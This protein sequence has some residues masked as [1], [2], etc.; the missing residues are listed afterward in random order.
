MKPIFEAANNMPNIGEHV[1]VPNSVTGKYEYLKCVF[2]KQD[3]SLISQDVDR[4]SVV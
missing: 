3:D 2:I 1:Y 4:K